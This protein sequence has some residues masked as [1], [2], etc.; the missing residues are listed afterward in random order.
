MKR[1]LFP[2]LFIASLLLVLVTIAAAC[3]DDDDGEEE[4]IT[5]EDFTGTWFLSSAGLYV[6]FN[7][8][9]T[10]RAASSVADLED[11]PFDLGQFRLEG[12]LFTF[13]TSDESPLCAGQSGSYQVE[14]TEEGELQFAL[15]EDPNCGPR[16]SL[17]SG[18][19]SGPL[20][21]IEP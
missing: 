21:R 3:G 10:F 5:V 14:L 8:D 13:T 12:T 16:A 6:Q 20:S 17:T 11:E 19:A 15:E 7:E 1:R 9:G 2:F 4:G 18:I